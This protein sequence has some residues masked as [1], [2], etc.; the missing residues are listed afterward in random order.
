[1]TTTPQT[2]PSP[3]WWGATAFTRFVFLIGLPIFA[4]I[5]GL[6]ANAVHQ[7]GPGDLTSGYVVGASQGCSAHIATTPH[8]PATLVVQLKSGKY[9]CGK[10]AAGHRIYYDAGALKEVPGPSN[11]VVGTALLGLLALAAAVCSVLVWI[12]WVGLRRRTVER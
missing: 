5:L 2:S 7:Q 11:Y 6:S 1:M 4:V 9:G 10:V 8:G 3:P 12:S